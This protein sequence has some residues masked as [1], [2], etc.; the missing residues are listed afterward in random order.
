VRMNTTEV[1]TLYA[2]NR[3]ANRTVLKT[4]QS[5]KWQDFIQDLSASH[6][7]IRGTLVHILWGEWLWLRRWRGES[8]KQVFAAEEFS[9]WAALESQ[10]SAVEEE[11]NAFLATLTDELLIRRVSYENLQGIRWEYSLAEM[12]QHLVNHSS[13]H[14]GQIAVLLRQLGQT[15]MATDFLVFLDEQ[16]ALAA[17]GGS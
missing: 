17:G 11:Q 1:R 10:W 7:S 13:Y 3:W 2:Y 16:R 8:P 9:D 4:S 6:G 5:L 14:R 12:M 15:P